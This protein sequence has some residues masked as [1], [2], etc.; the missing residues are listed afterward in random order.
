MS[1]DIDRILRL[2]DQSRINR[3]VLMAH[4]EARETFRLPSMRAHDSREFKWIVTTYYQHHVRHTGQ[5]TASE[6]EAFGEVKRLLDG[7]YNEDPY[8]EGYNVALRMGTDGARGGLR[9][10]V[11]QIADALKR[12]HMQKYMDHV[13]F[14]HIDPLSKAD[15]LALSRAFYQRFGSIL[16]EFGAEFDET[17]FAWNTRAALEY[18]RQI[19]EQLFGIAKKI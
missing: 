13:F 7:V 8:Q 12:R 11:N 15:N 10:V 2:L 5:G 19:L 3:D 4:D 16:R 6:E 17:T 18:H 9:E 1:V 14:D